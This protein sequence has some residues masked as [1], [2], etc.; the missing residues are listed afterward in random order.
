MVGQDTSDSAYNRRPPNS[1]E[2]MARMRALARAQPNIALIKYWGKSDA[3]RNLPAVGSLSLTLD[4]L[5]TTMAVEFG[6]ADTAA[7]SLT[8]NGATDERMLARVSKALD[9]VA[10]ARRKPATVASESN[11]PIAAG[12]ASS[13]SAFAALTV[14]ASAAA[15]RDADALS[16]ARLAG[17]A[18]G[19]AARSLFGG[20]VELELIEEGIDLRQLAAPDDWALAVVVAINNVGAKPVSSGDAMNRCAQT[21]P[22][23]GRWIALQED[24]LRVARGAVADRD[25]DTLAE[26]SEHNCLKMHSVM[27]TAKPP[28]VYWNDTTLLCMEKVR[29]L[30]AAGIPAFFTIDAG[31]QVKVV[32]L[33]GAVDEVRRVLAAVPGVREVMTSGLGSGAALLPDA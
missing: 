15:G 30:R 13:A 31:P 9:R 26:V 24:D 32:C 33:R 1:Y 23:Y 10:G 18:S 2:R 5:W 29:E 12:L 27:W 20:I 28:I 8:V 14:A 7:D 3:A 17:A 6:E 16:L 25:F 11:F 19:S 21:S 22:F 4:S